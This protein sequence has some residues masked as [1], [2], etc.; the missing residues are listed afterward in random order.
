[1]ATPAADRPNGRTLV[2]FD[3]D[4]TLAV[5]AQKAPEAIVDMLARLRERYSVGIVR[6]ASLL[7][8]LLAS[9]PHLHA[10]APARP[11]AQVGAGDY[12]KQEGQ[13][14]G[15]NL[16]ERLD[17]CFSE[18]GV[19]A[20]RGT[21]QIHCK[22]I[23]EHLGEGLWAAF[24]A[25]IQS[26]LDAERETTAKL[27]QLASPG[28]LLADRSVFLERRQCTVNICPIGRTPGLSQAERG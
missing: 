19:H 23:V 2:L 18:N 28:A 9:P 21:E 20:F 5:P 27:L 17:Y 16:Q 6:A 25:G 10:L 8:L 7:A 1:M 22:S 11:R 12:K 13:L 15:P 4:G 14:G 24:E 3:V 26:I